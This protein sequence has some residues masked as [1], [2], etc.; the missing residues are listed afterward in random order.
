MCSAKGTSVPLQIKRPLS[1][2]AGAAAEAWQ[3][4]APHRDCFVPRNDLLGHE[5]A[6]FLAM[7]CWGMRL[8]R[9]SQ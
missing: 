6:S 5:I 1:L 2:R 3:S 9:P 4:R 8:L 7:T